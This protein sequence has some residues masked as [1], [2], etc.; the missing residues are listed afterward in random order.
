M[1]TGPAATI[2]STVT[3]QGGLAQF[4]SSLGITPRLRA[5]LED[6]YGH[7]KIPRLEVPDS[8]V[9]NDGWKEV[10]P[11]L[12]PDDF[13]SVIGLP[14]LGYPKVRD[15][16]LTSSRLMYMP[17]ASRSSSVPTQPTGADRSWT[18]SRAG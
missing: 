3:D 15:S 14:V 10:P 1:S 4:V 5:R 17:P 6:E 11:V 2:F 8:T 12:R 18:T 13:S 7:A 9:N 16:V